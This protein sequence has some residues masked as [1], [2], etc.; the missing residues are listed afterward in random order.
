MLGV[1]K[2][3]QVFSEGERE[4]ESWW[5][6]GRLTKMKIQTSVGC[7]LQ[8]NHILSASFPTLVSKENIRSHRLWACDMCTHQSVH[9]LKRVAPWTNSYALVK[10]HVS[11]DW[12]TLLSLGD[13]GNNTV[14]EGR[15]L[16]CVGDGN[17]CQFSRFSE[18]W[19][20]ITIIGR[21]CFCGRLFQILT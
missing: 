17:M 16:F 4:N 19:L 14:G 10:C 12:Q 21:V 18:I 5:G 13:F 7:L 8:I 2:F 15:Y 1:K 11:H 6:W 20:N 9:P 3:N